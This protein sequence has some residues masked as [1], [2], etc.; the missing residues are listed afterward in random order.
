ML[1]LGNQQAGLLVPTALRRAQ[2]RHSDNPALAGLSEPPPE[3]IQCDNKKRGLMALVK[4][5]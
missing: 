5:D 3:S 1:A 2:N 4:R